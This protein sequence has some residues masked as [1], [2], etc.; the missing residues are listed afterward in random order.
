MATATGSIDQIVEAMSARSVSLEQILET[1]FKRINH[2]NAEVHALI[3]VFPFSATEIDWTRT[4]LKARTQERR[5]QPLLG[6]PIAVNCDIPTVAGRTTTGSLALNFRSR[7]DAPIVERLT[8]AGAIIIGKAN[9][10]EWG[11]NRD[12]TAGHG[13]SALGGQTLGVHHVDQDPSGSSSGAAVAVA[14]GLCVAAV[15]VEVRYQLS[16]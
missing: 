9:I 7:A 14:L 15:G 1:F 2:V 3:E 5:E 13:W 8:D 10:T 4:R 16:I 6:V 12:R 11:N